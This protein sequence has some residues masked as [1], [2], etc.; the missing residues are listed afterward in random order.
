MKLNITIECLE[1]CPSDKLKNLMNELLTLVYNEESEIKSVC[2]SIVE[3][4]NKI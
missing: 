2:C 3:E 4:E 1:N